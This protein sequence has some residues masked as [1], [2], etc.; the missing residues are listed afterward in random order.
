[1]KPKHQEQSLPLFQ[2]R[3]DQ[4]INMS[5]PLSRL[6]RSIGWSVFEDEFEG[7]YCDDNGRPGKSIR[8]MVGLHYLKHAF[9]ESDESVV[10]RFLEN[11]YWQYF[12]GFEYFQHQFPIDPTSLVKWRKRVGAENLELLLKETVSTARRGKLLKKS[13][14]KRINVDTTVQEKAITYPTDAKLYQKMRLKLVHASKERGICLR[15][16]YV[17]LGKNAYIMQGR[18]RHARQHRRAARMVKNL[19][20]Y[21]GR[22]ERDIRR[23]VD[24]PDV[25]LAELLAMADRLR[26]Q[27][28]QSKNKLYSIHEPEVE[29]ISK[30]KAHKKYEFG[31]KVGVVSTSKRNWII[32]ARAFHQNPY[33]GHTLQG[34]VD[35]AESLCGDSF[36]HIYVDRGYRGHNYQGAAQ[37][38][39]AGSKGKKS[40]WER[41]WRKRR[42]AVEP[43]IGHMKY[44]NRMIR[45]YLKG[46][47]GDQ[48]NAI[49]AA[50]GYNI[51]KLLKAFF[52]PY[53]REAVLQIFM[54][55]HLHLYPKPA[56]NIL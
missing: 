2:S 28:R 55:N 13:D 51:R 11:P 30:G 32:G 9:N 24:A 40:R 25:E 15:Q 21:L 50:C 39:I 52:L 35:Q 49:L 8:L 3:L 12:C 23:K 53:F 37:V 43:V 7:Y 20:N 22:V 26:Q 5:H 56:L 27:Q 34:S 6:A 14:C 46:Q 4:I 18:Y 33:D 31:C 42:A 47:E 45:N 54:K 29:C 38:H 44:D 16:S 10:A 19:K 1:M 48:I 17:R 36:D 41:M